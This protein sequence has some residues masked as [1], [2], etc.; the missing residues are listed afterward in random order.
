MIKVYNNIILEN[1]S[2]KNR[3]NYQKKIKQLN[4]EIEDLKDELYYYIGKYGIDHKLTLK[5]SQEVD[6]KLNK[7]SFVTRNINTS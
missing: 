4:L 1:I 7:F 2:L 5:K 6:V 3:Y